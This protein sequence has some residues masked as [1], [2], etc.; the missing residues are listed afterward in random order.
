MLGTIQKCWLDLK[1]ELNIKQTWSHT[2]VSEQGSSDAMERPAGLRAPP[3]PQSISSR[4][5]F[6][7]LINRS[8]VLVDA[9]LS[10]LAL[11]SPSS[12]QHSFLVL[13]KTKT[14]RDIEGSP[15]WRRPELG[16][17]A[18]RQGRGTEAPKAHSLVCLPGKTEMGAMALVEI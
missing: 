6:W 15:G 4:C 14:S 8:Q 12:L 7:T 10:F 2:C 13:L 5:S 18:G 1:N 11:P 9:W 17:G 16:E 3:A